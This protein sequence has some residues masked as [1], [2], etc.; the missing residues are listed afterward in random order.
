MYIHDIYI[1]TYMYMYI[2]RERERKRERERGRER[3]STAAFDC[4][5][6]MYLLLL[7]FAIKSAIPKP[8]DM[9][10]LLVGRLVNS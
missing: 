6:P 1:Y 4:Q 8:L 7:A 3:E 10:L 2:E 9:C 5:A